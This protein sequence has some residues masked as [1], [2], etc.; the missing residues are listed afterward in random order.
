MNIVQLNNLI[1]GISMKVK[2]VNSFSTDDVYKFWNTAEVK[3]GSVV[4]GIKNAETGSGLITY[5]CILYYGDRLLENRTNLESIYS[6]AT[7]SLNQIIGTLENIDD[8]T[9]NGNY[10]ITYFTQKFADELAG[11]YV[12]LNI[13]VAQ[14]NIA[15]GWDGYIA[16]GKSNQNKTVEVIEN[17]TIGTTNLSKLSES[18]IQV[19]T[20]KGW[21]LN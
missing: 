7:T 15:C 16:A 19:A 11:G 3:Y 5:S 1:E 8:I 18:D 12:E 21:T 4:F 10:R 20:D 9:I 14:N 6:D 2:F 13:Q 17:G